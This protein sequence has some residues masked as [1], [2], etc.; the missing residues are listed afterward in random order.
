M[1]LLALLSLTLL[2]GAAAADVLA[3]G[4]QSNVVPYPT[5]L[6]IRT[7]DDGTLVT[8]DGLLVQRWLPSGALIGTVGSFTVAG[9]VGAFA[10]APSQNFV[11]VGNSTTGEMI[12][13]NVNGGPQN[14]AGTVLGN[15]DAVFLNDTFAVVSA[16]PC[17]TDCGTT[18]V[19]LSALTGFQTNLAAVEGDPG[20]VALDFNKNLFYGTVDPSQAADSTEIVQF[21]EADVDNPPPPAFQ[22]NQGLVVIEIESVPAAGSWTPST[23]FPG[24][25]GTSYYRWDGP[26]LFS[27]PGVD[28]LIYQFDIT[29]PGDYEFHL[30]NRHEDPQPDQEN[31][32]WV[33]VDNGPWL[34]VFSNM[35]AATVGVWNWHSIAEDGGGAQF[36]AEYNLGVGRHT[37]QISGRSNGF[38]IDRMVFFRDYVSD[39]LDLA[40]PQSTFASL[41]L[42]NTTTLACCFD[43][44]TDLVYDNE[45]DQF[46][47]AENNSVLGTNRVVNVLKTG[48]SANYVIGDPF[49]T[50]AN[51]DFTHE[52]DTGVYISFQPPNNGELSYTRTDGGALNERRVLEPAR[53]VLSITGPGAAT[54]LGITQVAVD[55]AFPNGVVLYFFAA[56]G[57][58]APFE[59][60]IFLMGLPLIH[61]AF[62]SEVKVLP[63][64][65]IADPTGSTSFVFNNT[66]GT[67]DV[68]ALQAVITDIL[69]EVLGSSTI[70]LL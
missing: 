66:L 21:D 29:D 11:L 34:K 57:T 62:L 42:S 45:V 59:Y 22:A 38:K 69:G 56:A 51:L 54:G 65:H 27:N 58:L 19:K 12:R 3:P 18:L 2:S 70:N 6:A 32:C 39:G 25:T 24:F 43:G 44:A 35:G 37:V 36:Q 53:P 10:V 67:T 41:N 55:G 1:K 33:K 5:G 9:P 48:V 47:L 26:D 15:F 50:I 64:P 8:C 7:L 40:K 52:D 20:P 46:F 31:D 13:C 17:G 61:T 14:S 60:P 30:H 23:T 4:F 28:P 16:A 68:F 49:N 63:P